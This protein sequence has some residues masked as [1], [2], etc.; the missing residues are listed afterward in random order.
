MDCGVRVYIYNCAVD[1]SLLVDRKYAEKEIKNVLN[2]NE[3]I[4][5]VFENKDLS[6]FVDVVLHYCHD[7]DRRGLYHFAHNIVK[8]LKLSK[9]VNLTNIKDD[10]L[11]NIGYC[12]EAFIN[13][14]DDFPWNRSW[15]SSMDE[16]RNY[17]FNPLGESNDN[18]VCKLCNNK[19]SLLDENRRCFYGCKIPIDPYIDDVFNP[20]YNLEDYKES[21]KDDGSYEVIGK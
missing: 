16:F 6:F 19:T 11:A 20:S 3:N 10:D 13:F 17:Y 4:N 9:V 21:E 1:H 15:T 7:A 8:Y 12:F 14:D 18:L 5:L 2:L